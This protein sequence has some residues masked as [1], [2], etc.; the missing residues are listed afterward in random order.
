LLGY[1]AG[2]DDWTITTDGE[3]IRQY[4]PDEMRLLV[5]WN[6]EVYADID[7]VDKNM[8]HSADLTHEMVFERLLGDLRDKGV[9]V[10][11]PSDPLHDPDFIRALIATYTIAPTT[12]WLAPTAA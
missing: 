8:D 7:E 2:R 9:D 6:A 1:D 10:G 5:H 12:D 4:R 11:E 3:V